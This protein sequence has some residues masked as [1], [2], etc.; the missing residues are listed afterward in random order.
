[1]QLEE[2]ILIATCIS[3]LTALKI[4]TLAVPLDGLSANFL[5]FADEIIR[6][7]SC[8]AKRCKYSF[9]DLK[10]NLPLQLEYKCLHYFSKKS[11]SKLLL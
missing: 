10:A 11:T 7:L 6:C 9:E 8:I 2:L 5:N 3:S 1:M 4:I